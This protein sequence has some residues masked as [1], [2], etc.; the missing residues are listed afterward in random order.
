MSKLSGNYDVSESFKFIQICVE[1]IAGD[2]KKLAFV[3]WRNLAA[4]HV[5]GEHNQ[6]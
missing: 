1:A 6:S 2:I 5:V 3:S 4:V